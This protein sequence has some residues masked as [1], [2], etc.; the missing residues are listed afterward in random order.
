M[1]T[2]HQANIAVVLNAFKRTTYLE[3]QLDAIE[4]QTIKPSKIYVWQ[5]AAEKIP[6]HLK[7]RFI[8]AECSENLGV[9]ARF[10]FALNIDA[11]YI[12]I[13]DD[14]TIP[15]NRWFENCI[16]TI[17]EHNGLLGTRGLR[18]MSPKRYHPFEHYGWGNPNEETIQVDIV[19]HAWFFRRE[20]LAMF[21]S[22]MPSQDASKIAGEDIHFSYMLQKYALGT[23][24]PPHPKDDTSLWGSLPEYGK[25][26][27]TDENAISSDQTAL[28]RFDIALQYYTD[29][30]FTLYL[31]LSDRLKKGVVIGSGVRGNNAIRNLVNKNP[32]IK[33]S[34]KWILTKLEKIGIHI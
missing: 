8:L 4:S 16:N 22:E 1:V 30:G 7:S 5:N 26:I 10:A 21:W 2:P 32:K 23:Y 13:F 6:D 31:G 14:D 27:G 18:Y 19:G 29:R 11:D 17:Q 15:G 12:C 3:T 9:W 24:V 28:S 34:A 25:V 20:H 33:A